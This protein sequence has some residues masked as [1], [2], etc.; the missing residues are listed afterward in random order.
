L[1]PAPDYL[2]QQRA[3]MMMM[4]ELAK[5]TS[6]VDVYIVGSNNTGVGGPGPR[7]AGAPATPPAAPQPQRPQSPTQRHFGMANSAG[8]PA[9]NLPNGFADTGSPT[10]AVIYAQPYR[11]L[12]IIALAKAYQ[13][14][15]GFHTRKPAKL[16]AT[17][18]TQA[19]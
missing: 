16:D 8:Y 15:A 14:A 18:T 13:D 3:R 5:A 12:E 1:I 17:T 2:Q 11:E 7:A 6:H 4:I 9:I 19:Q 10:N